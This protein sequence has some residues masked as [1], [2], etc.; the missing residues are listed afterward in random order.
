MSQELIYYAMSL[1]LTSIF[2]HTASFVT[3]D[4][5]WYFLPHIKKALVLTQVRD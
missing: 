3:C 2:S 1:T 4:A 5:L